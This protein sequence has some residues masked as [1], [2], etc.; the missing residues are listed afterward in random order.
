MIKFDLDLF[1]TIGYNAIISDF[2]LI[3]GGYADKNNFGTY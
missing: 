1:K 2:A 3:L